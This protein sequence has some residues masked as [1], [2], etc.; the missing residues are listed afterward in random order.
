M[1]PGILD[2]GNV[3]SLQLLAGIAQSVLGALCQRM[4]RAAIA[5]TRTLH[6]AVLERGLDGLGD[7]QL[8]DIGLSRLEPAGTLAYAQGSHLAFNSAG[9]W[10][11]REV[12]YFP[13]HSGRTLAPDGLEE[14]SGCSRR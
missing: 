6:A 11:V 1:I 2:A 12:H 5:G 8:R 10:L 3:L 4:T 14:G 7:R 13:V 9:G